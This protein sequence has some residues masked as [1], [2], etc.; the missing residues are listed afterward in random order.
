MAVTR[1]IDRFNE[2]I[3]GMPKL[4]KTLEESESFEITNITHSEERRL[5]I[6]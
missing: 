1:G 2:F 5:C 3:K 6:L 4:L